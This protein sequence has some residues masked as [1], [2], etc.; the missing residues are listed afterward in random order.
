M[1]EPETKA[2]GS[3]MEGVPGRSPRVRT[4]VTQALPSG[5]G[6]FA[7]LAREGR[8]FLRRIFGWVF[9]RLIR[10]S[11]DFTRRNSLDFALGHRLCGLPGSPSWEVMP[12]LRRR[13]QSRDPPATSEDTI[14]VGSMAVV[15]PLR[16]GGSETSRARPGSAGSTPRSRLRISLGRS[17]LRECAHILL[18]VGPSA[19]EERA[20]T[21]PYVRAQMAGR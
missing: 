13:D 1:V 18:A 14:A 17:R 2:T 3:P 9:K 5:H 20:S 21:R 11:S 12:P 16:L 6:R 4:K 10:V 19:P 8:V 7:G 15:R